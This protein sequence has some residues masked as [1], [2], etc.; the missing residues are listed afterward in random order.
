MIRDLGERWRM[1]VLVEGLF[2]FCYLAAVTIR[3]HNPDLWEPS[4]G[5]E[6]PMDFAYF[7]AVL[8][9]DVVPALRPLVR[10]RLHALLL[11]WLRA[12]GLAD[13]L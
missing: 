12:V 6:K 1:L 4:R 13:P 10:R 7:N 5:G 2:L 3:G 8:K 11:L 9:S